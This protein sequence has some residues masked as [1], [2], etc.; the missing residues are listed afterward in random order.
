[1]REMSLVEGDFAS[2]KGKARKQ[3]AKDFITIWCKAIAR[4]DGDDFATEWGMRKKRPH[5]KGTGCV[6]PVKMRRGC[7]HEEDAAVADASV[8]DDD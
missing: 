5:K 2:A 4:N 1:M 3:G 6:T 7:D 8:S